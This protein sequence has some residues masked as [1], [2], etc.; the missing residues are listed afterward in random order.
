M[1]GNQQFYGFAALVIP[2]LLFGGA[3]SQ[4]WQP[5]LK[6]KPSEEGLALRVW[7]TMMFAIVA[8]IVAII[9]AFG[10]QP[11]EWERIL[12]G[13][14]VGVGT[15]AAAG[16]VAWP[17]LE[18]FDRAARNGLVVVGVVV[19][20]AATVF[21]LFNT[22][23]SPEAE[24]PQT[25]DGLKLLAVATAQQQATARLAGVVAD[26]SVAQAQLEKTIKRLAN[27]VRRP[28]RRRPHAAAARHWRRGVMWGRRQRPTLPRPL[29]RI[30]AGPWEHV[31]VQ[32]HPYGTTFPR[33][34]AGR[35][36]VP[37]RHVRGT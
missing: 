16:A 34:L 8:E 10:R 18:R 1:A 14:A 12:V 20:L 17:W 7:A 4:S 36:R 5:K 15:V 24:S 9:A 2:V 23:S 31:G 26:D 28:P 19:G 29:I 22:S 30:N 37:P 32:E 27:E 13:V 11:E 6:D 35:R 25:K 3:V 21:L 33:R